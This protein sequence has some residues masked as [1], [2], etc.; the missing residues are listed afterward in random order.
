MSLFHRRA[1]EPPRFP[2]EDYEPLLRSS[3]CTGEQTACVR[4]R[5]TGKIREVQLIRGQ[6]DLEEFCRACGAK[7]EELRTIY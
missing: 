7:P 1:P 5:A 4:E 6:K 2:P 3:V